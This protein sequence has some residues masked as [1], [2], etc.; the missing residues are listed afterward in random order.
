MP[1]IV[2]LF[3]KTFS[4]SAAGLAIFITK[5]VRAFHTVPA[6]T[7]FSAVKFKT[8]TAFN[9]VTFIFKSAIPALLTDV[10][11]VVGAI[12]A[13]SA[14]YAFVINIIASLAI[15]AVRSAYNPAVSTIIP[16]LGAHFGAVFAKI[17]I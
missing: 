12:T 1:F 13:F 16:A 8:V 7:V 10:A 17:A 6:G 14:S 4:A 9:A 15:G 2:K 11:I 5:T 3:C